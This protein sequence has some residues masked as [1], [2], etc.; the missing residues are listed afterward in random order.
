MSEHGSAEIKSSTADQVAQLVTARIAAEGLAPGD[1]IGAERELAERYGV[2]RWLI[3][4]ALEQLEEQDLIL[5]THGRSGGVFVG[6]R[7]VVRDLTDLVGLP[8]YL[9]DQGLSAGTTVLGTR[10]VP[11][12]DALAVE[13]GLASDDWVFEIERLRLAEGLPLSLEV[14]C[15]PATMFPGMLGKALDGSLYEVLEGHYGIVRGEAIETIT[16]IPA[17]RERASSLQVPTGSP[18]LLVTR[19]AHLATGERF[20]HSREL[21][22]ADRIAITVHTSSAGPLKKHMR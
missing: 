7:K 3:R 9:R 2:S 17:D 10:A 5:R 14:C 16:A 12:G 21:Y 20:E 6:H 19:T 8:Q 22:R 13:L 4:K 1:R 18:L 15:F 11:A